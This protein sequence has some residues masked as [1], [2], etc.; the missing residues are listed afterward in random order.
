MFL[1]PWSEKAPTDHRD[2]QGRFQA[3]N[4][5]S[6]G[7]GWKAAIRRVLGATSDDPVANEVIRQAP[8]LA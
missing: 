7:N 8:M 3:G 1:A 4:A 5:V 6:V 2:A